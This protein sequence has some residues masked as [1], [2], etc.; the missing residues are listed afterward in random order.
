MSGALS[1]WG[2][3]WGEVSLLKGRTGVVTE[4]TFRREPCFPL[5]RFIAS[6][7]LKKPPCSPLTSRW[8]LFIVS[9]RILGGKFFGDLTLMRPKV[10]PSESSTY[11][12]S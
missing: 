8:I 5:K 11:S 9:D 12:G 2:I 1:V 3:V 7:G 6:P 10:I 4:G